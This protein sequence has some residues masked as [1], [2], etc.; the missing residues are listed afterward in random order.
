MPF[1]LRYRRSGQNRPCGTIGPPEEERRSIRPIVAQLEQETALLPDHGRSPVCVVCLKKDPCSN[2]NAGR[3]V[4]AECVT[5]FDA[6]IHAV[7]LPRPPEN[8]R[9]IQ[10]TGDYPM[11]SIPASVSNPAVRG[12]GFHVVRQ[13]ERRRRWHKLHA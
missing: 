8:P 3:G 13:D 4:E 1:E 11:I 5:Y 10:G 9:D 12:Q 2:R 6:V 7:E